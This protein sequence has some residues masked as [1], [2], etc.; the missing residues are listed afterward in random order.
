MHTQCAQNA[1][2]STKKCAE[3]AHDFSVH[4]A[5]K[6]LMA[7]IQSDW[8]KARKKE[9]RVSD[10]A[11]GSAIGIERSVVNKIIS[12]KV[13]FNHRYADGFARALNMTREDVLFRFGVLEEEPASTAPAI[14]EDAIPVAPIPVIG[15]IAAGNW[16]EAVRKSTLS[17]PAPLP[18]M[19]PQ[20]FARR[21]TAWTCWSRTAQ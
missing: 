6:A 9:L 1:Q 18:S 21:A 10:E 7:A 12:G 11:I 4:D 19:P 14:P 20:A 13:E 15:E 16:R 8:L 5:H 2:T 17:I 3:H